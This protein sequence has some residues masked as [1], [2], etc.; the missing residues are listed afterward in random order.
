MSLPDSAAEYLGGNER[1]ASAS[2]DV[3]ERVEVVLLDAFRNRRF[4]LV[5]EV[6]FWISPK[7]E[8]RIDSRWGKLCC[9]GCERVPV[10]RGLD[11]V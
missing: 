8:L 3:V 5:G 7:V 2:L 9:Y 11:G 10:L 4:F 6:S 1:V